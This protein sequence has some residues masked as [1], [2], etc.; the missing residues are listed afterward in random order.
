[1]RRFPAL[2]DEAAQAAG[3]LARALARISEPLATL[4]ERL[5]ARLDDEA[6]ELDE[7]TRNRIEAIGR[8][9]TR[10]R[11]EPAAAWQTMLG[12][13]TERQPDPGQRPN[14]VLFLRLDRRDGL[15]D[16]DVGL[17]RHWLDPTD[18]VRRHPGGPGARGAGHHRRR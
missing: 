15:R 2:N 10:R 6:E 5:L 1:M 4:R 9:L 8:S 11:A 16:L 7:A 14:H 12:S 17:H 3:R 13:L 18:P